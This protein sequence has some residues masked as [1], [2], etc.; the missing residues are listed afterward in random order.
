M[1]PV[2]DLDG[3]PLDLSTFMALA[4]GPVR[5]AISDNVQRRL[6]TARTIVEAVL[7]GN[8]PVYGLNTGLGANLRHRIPEDAIPDFQAQLLEG[9]MV[10]VGELLPESVCRAA[11]IARI[12]GAAKGGSGLSVESFGQLVALAERGM[13]PAISSVGSIGAGDLA[14]AA[15]MGGALIG[16]GR[17]WVDG[18]P[19]PAPDALARAGL[20]PLRLQP[21]DALALAN[22]SAVTTALAAHAAHAAGRALLRG[23]A[24]ATLSGEGY[25]MN[26]SILDTRINNLRPARGQ[27]DAAAWLRAAFAGSAL[28]APGAARSIQDPLSF[29]TI[30]PVFGA[31]RAALNDLTNEIESE[32]NGIADNPVVLIPPLHSV[33]QPEEPVENGEGMPG[34]ESLLSTPNFH[35]NALALALDSASI[36]MAHAAQSSAQRLVKLMMPDLTGLPRYLSPVGGASA[37]YVPLQKTA[38]ALLAD[39]RRHAQPASLDVMSVSDGVEDVAPQTPL[40]AASM[41]EQTVAFHHLAAAEALV[42]AQAADLRNPATVGLLPGML[43][44]AIR[45]RIAS[46]DA[47]RPA[48]GDLAYAADVLH[49]LSDDDL[50]PFDRDP[51]RPPPEG[52]PG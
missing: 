41:S 45:D 35:T 22:H 32:L 30:A 40:A 6:E 33:S 43:H 9:R 46:L 19:V 2:L 28:F 17:I 13:A 51:T 50:N 20:T 18:E 16:H 24:V 34:I 52:I 12:V 3:P 44:A 7:A 38:A 5:I 25:G 1:D 27:S 47:D 36:A 15:E 26:L 4:S 48:V 49:S 29:R 14:L 23:M 37:G 39:I 8:R 31:A 11:L 42:A 10:G 21:K